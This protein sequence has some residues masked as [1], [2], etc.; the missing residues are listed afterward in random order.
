MHTFFPEN[1]GRWEEEFATYFSWPEYPW[2]AKQ[3]DQYLHYLYVTW[4]ITMWT[5][6]NF[7]L[8][9]REMSA[10]QIQLNIKRFVYND[11]V[12]KKTSIKILM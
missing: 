5:I 12:E 9:I 11:L 4:K 6:I 3:E 7:S 10:N 8:I 2:A 1:R